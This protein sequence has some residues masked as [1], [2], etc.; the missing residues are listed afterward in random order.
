MSNVPERMLVAGAGVMGGEVLR[1]LIAADRKAFALV[2]S[3]ERAESL[4]KLGVELVEGNFADRNSWKRALEDVTA[5]FNIV[6]TH[7]D[8]VTWNDV[9]LD[10]AKQSGVRH[11]VQLS[12]I[13]V[14]PKSLAEFHRQ[15]SQCDEA[16]RESGLSYTI[17]RPNVFYQNML[18]MAGSIREHGRFRSA[19]GDARISMIDV[20]DIAEVAVKALTECGHS[21]NVYVLTGPQALTYFDVAKLLSDA[22]GKPVTYEALTE[23][24]AVRELTENGVP[25]PV[26]RSRVGVHRS[27]ST[28]AFAETTENVQTLLH[29]APRSFGRICTRLCF[30]ISLTAKAV[31]SRS[32][33]SRVA[34]AC[35][36][37]GE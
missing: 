19:V 26:A 35:P 5:V 3:P 33:R 23:D 9:F 8:A 21:G 20:R 15:M 10:C 4:Q 12:G 34:R 17:L 11:V 32:G 29:R 14:S 30:L 6:V 27:F 1:Q 18:R 24:E 16:L 7:R 13:S 37:S 36:V 2:R 25:E 28:G 31:T 22:I